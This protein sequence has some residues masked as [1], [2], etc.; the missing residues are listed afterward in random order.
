[1]PIKQKLSKATGCV[2]SSPKALRQYL[3]RL[4]GVLDAVGVTSGVGRA[5]KPRYPTYRVN[6]ALGFAH[7]GTSGRT[8]EEPLCREGSTTLWIHFHP[9]NGFLS[10]VCSVPNGHV[11]LKDKE[12]RGGPHLLAL[13]ASSPGDSK[14]KGECSLLLSQAGQQHSERK[15]QKS[16]DSAIE[17]KKVL[18]KS[19]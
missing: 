11:Y 10:L 3:S 8:L 2:P 6:A 4:M 9:G 19:H 12:S 5:R 7:A 14:V 15:R 18:M 17:K 16:V 1:M 13:R